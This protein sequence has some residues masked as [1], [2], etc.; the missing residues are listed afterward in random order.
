MNPS[1]L[2]EKTHIKYMKAALKQAQKA[3]QLGESSYW[4][5]DRT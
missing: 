4:L 1:E 2:T 3:Y 5:R